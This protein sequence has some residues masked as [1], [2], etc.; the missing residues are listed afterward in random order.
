MPS[1]SR[2]SN[3]EDDIV[4]VGRS[5][6]LARCSELLDGAT[7]ATARLELIG[8]PGIGKTAIVEA[9]VDDARRRGWCVLR[10]RPTMAESSLGCAGLS[11]LLQTVDDLDALD[12]HHRRAVEIALCRRANDGEPPSTSELG[13]AIA[14]LL[15]TLTHDRSLLI[16]IDD[17]QWMDATSAEVMAYATRRLPS[18][19]VVL[20]VARRDEGTSLVE[21]SEQLQ[22]RPL[23]VHA[24][25]ELVGR[26]GGEE[27]SPGLTNR[28]VIA[29]GG[30]PLFAIELS[31]SLTERPSE[32]VVPLPLPGSLHELVAGRVGSLPPAT[33]E[34][35]ALVALLGHPSVE[36]LDRL[37]ALES[38]APAE[39][40]GTIQIHDRTVQFA[41]P[42]LA[43][44]AHDAV[45]GTARLALHRRLATVTDGIER[46]V[47]LALGTEQPDTAIAEALALGVEAAVARGA[48]AEAAELAL[49]AVSIS[50]ADDPMR[51]Q[52]M[53]L[54]GDTMFRAGRTDEAIGQLEQ[55]RSGAGSADDISRALLALST[56]EYSHTDNADLAADLARDALGRS[57]DPALRAE[58]HTVLARVLYSDFAEAADHATWALE[59]IEAGPTPAPRA[60]A[61]ALN[62]AASADFMA[63]RGLD[64]ERFDRAIDLERGSSIS[65]ADS[66]AGAYAAFLKYADELDESRAR[67]AQLV[68]DADAGSLPYALGHLPQ[69]ELWSGNW[70]VAEQCANRQIELAR[71]TQQESQV[72][73]GVFNLAIVAAHRGDVTA[74]TPLA[75]SLVDEGR[76]TGTLWTERNGV[77]L[78]GFLAMIRGDAVAAVDLLA[79]YDEIG[80]TMQLREPGYIRFHGDYVEGLVTIGEVARAV[81]V[82][83]RI[84]PIAVR[85]GRPSAVGTV[86]RGRALVLAHVGDSAPAIAAARASVAA[87]D[88]TALVYERARAL[89]TLGMVL[90][91]FKLRADARDAL[92]EALET[93]DRMGARSF[94]ER[95]TAELGRVGGRAGEPSALTQTESHVAE[96]A[97]AGRTTRQIAD[98]LFISSKTVEANLTRIYR[99]LHVSNRAELSNRLADRG[100]AEHTT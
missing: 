44:A 70:D 5:E 48:V 7:A 9:V 77:G 1:Q 95:T 42:L 20:I 90:R 98:A 84:E 72:Q 93:F 21:R 65:A 63:G 14:A 91:R 99:K 23:T 45:P 94:V 31:R 16:T 25:V 40:A 89:L 38:L 69:L 55:V 32:P 76:A 75:Q 41:H 68:D 52:R 37:G 39:I 47:H 88:R 19:G 56:I 81:A 78:L 50:P 13:S 71:R 86:R 49:L 29:A 46:C 87:Y 60:L 2:R 28:I 30:N 27:L 17:F 83:D 80:E 6:E 66:A 26:H 85:L 22:M 3:G 64:R 18:S 92:T 53:L 79:R 12:E 4:L 57:V 100:R 67:F 59:L 62:A 35:L 43:S 97:A 61:M 51:W 10:A 74:A 96:L 24:I 82:L 8:E 33:V 15:R 54:C 58:A 11:D 34:A 73:A 36:A